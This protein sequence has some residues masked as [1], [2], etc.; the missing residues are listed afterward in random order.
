M[1]DHGLHIMQSVFGSC[2]YL[3]FITQKRL[4]WSLGFYNVIFK[5]TKEVTLKS[6]L[7]TSYLREDTEKMIERIRMFIS[8]IARQRSCERLELDL[9]LFRPGNM[10]ESIKLRHAYIYIYI[11]FFFKKAHVF[12]CSIFIFQVKLKT[13]LYWPM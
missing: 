7:L 8:K 13:W 4:Y 12:R 2:V 10:V 11:Y 9:I 1:K 6:G 3:I 5:N